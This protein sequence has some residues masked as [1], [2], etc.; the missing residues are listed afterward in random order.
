[1]DFLSFFL[2]DFVKQLQ[3]PTLGFLIG[4]MI[5]AALGSQLQIPESICKII[6]FMLLTKIGLTG[7]IG[8]RKSNLTEMVLPA[9]FAVMIGILV[10]FIARYTLAKLPK[11]KTVDAIATGGLFGAVSGSTMAAAL[12]LLEEQ[13]I[14]Y[15]AWAG[16]LYPFMDIPALVTAIVVAN[17][18]LNKKKLRAAAY[19]TMQESFDKQKDPAGNRVKIW[20]IIQESLQGPALSAM[21][22]G[23]ALGLFTKPESVYQSFYDP[24]FRGLL[25]ILMLVMGMEAWSRIGE[26]RKVAQWYVVY[27]VVAPLLHGFIAFGLGMIAHY[28]TGFSLGGV[29]ILSVIASSSSDISGPPTLRAGIPSA[30]PSAYIGASTAIGTPVAIGL[31][32]PLF[33]GLAQTLGGG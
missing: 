24:L 23:V 14:K 7:G 25:S 11:V 18:Y 29:V 17:I 10:V 8:I 27:S 31:A 12:T 20:P 33:I 6:V 32:I 4:G 19:S 22:L 15:E 2:M 3:S 9:A 5:I 28:T 26:L 16:A 1:M 13:G 30:N 21:L